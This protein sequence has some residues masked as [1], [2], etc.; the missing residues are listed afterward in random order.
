M[1]E[2][3]RFGS[4]KD[5]TI[6]RLTCNDEHFYTV[7]KP[8]VDNQQNISCIPTGYYKLVRVDSPRFGANTWEVANV[9]GRSHILIHPTGY[10]KLVRVDSPRF[11][12]NTWEV[13]NVTGRSHILIHVANTSADVIGCIG[14]GMGLFPQLQGVSTSRKAIENFYL[15]TADRTE[16]ELIIRNGA[17]D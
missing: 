13:A 3:I 4:F 7:E 16:E 10:Y 2:L 5:R 12:A 9:T 15:M 17:L 6:G 11:G 14:L 8:W 1:I